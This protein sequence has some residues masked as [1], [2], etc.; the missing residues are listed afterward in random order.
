MREIKADVIEGVADHERLEHAREGWER[1]VEIKH[2]KVHKGWVE[3]VREDGTGNEL[4]WG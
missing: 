1:G 2:S 3:E 4:G